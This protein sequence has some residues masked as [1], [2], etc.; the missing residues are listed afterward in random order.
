MSTCAGEGDYFCVNPKE[1]TN[2]QILYLLEKDRP[3]S[4]AQFFVLASYFPK[5]WRLVKP[6]GWFGGTLLDPLCNVGW[7]PLAAQK[8]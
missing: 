6:S 7:S 3:Q 2:M 5:D 4:S 1:T 8:L